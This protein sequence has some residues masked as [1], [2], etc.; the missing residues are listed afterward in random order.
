MATSPYKNVSF[1]GQGPLNQIQ[2]D[3]APSM[4]MAQQLMANGSNTAPVQSPLEGIARALQGGLGGYTNYATMKAMGDRQTAANDAM[5]KALSGAKAKEFDRPTPDFVG[6]M[7][8][9]P[10]GLQGVIDAGVG[11][12]NQDIMPFLQNAQMMKMQQDQAAQQAEID[13]RQGIADYETKLKIKQKYPVAG[14]GFDSTANIKDTKEQMAAQK[15]LDAAN[16]SGDPQAIA[17]AKQ[18]LENLNYNIKKSPEAILAQQAAKNQ[19]DINAAGKLA[20]EKVRSEGITKRMNVRVE[21]GM[22]AA[23]IMPTIV[24]SIELLD[25]VKTGGFDNLAL[26]AKQLFGVEGA[27]EAELSQNLGKAVISQLRSVFG[28]AFTAKEGSELK[29]IEAGFGK[30]VEGNRRMLKNL[31]KLTQRVYLQGLSAA[32]DLGDTGS[33]DSMKGLY[34]IKFGG[35]ETQGNPQIPSPD[36]TVQGGI[37]QLSPVDVQAKAW[38]EANPNDPRSAAILQRVNK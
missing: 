29:E 9:S 1:Y 2:R 38:A 5:I 23:K 22:A 26:K 8:G 3:Y 21:D 11:T 10:G 28:A 35:E 36:V 19:A 18:Y 30:S 24:R 7:Q 4:Q 17:Y 15:A 31:E 33:F 16:A 34:G 13:R 32:T 14:N 20:S 27:D 6:P 12:G 37:K 25:S